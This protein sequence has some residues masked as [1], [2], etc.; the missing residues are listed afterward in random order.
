MKLGAFYVW[1]YIKSII[2]KD[3]CILY[4][5]IRKMGKWDNFHKNH[6]FMK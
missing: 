6:I 1:F 4:N 3:I 2:K 5:Y